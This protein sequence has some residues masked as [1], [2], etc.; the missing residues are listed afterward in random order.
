MALTFLLRCHW[1]I[2][3]AS[4]VQELNTAGVIVD[5]MKQD[6]SVRRP[7]DTP[8]THTAKRR[9]GRPEKAGKWFV[10]GALDIPGYLADE[11]DDAS[12]TRS[13]WMEVGHLIW[14]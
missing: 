13:I 1:F 6:K 8:E 14:S 2:T 12:Q 5:P 10:W 9:R 7:A 4:V 3:V 11:A